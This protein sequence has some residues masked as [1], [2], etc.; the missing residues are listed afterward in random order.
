[1]QDQLRKITAINQG[2]YESMCLSFMNGSKAKLM[3][4]QDIGETSTPIKKLKVLIT[5]RIK[6]SA[7]ESQ[8]KLLTMIFLAR[9][10]KVRFSTVKTSLNNEY[11]VNKDN[12][13]ATLQAALNLLSHYQ[14]NPDKDHSQK[15][16]SSEPLGETS[17]GQTNIKKKSKKQAG[18]SQDTMQ[19]DLT[20][21]ST[22]NWNRSPSPAVLRTL[23]TSQAWSG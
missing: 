6:S 8:D 23:K 5:R 10:C 13:P 7:D 20:Q 22:R 1:M 16:G 2:K 15:K 19:D 21:S 11:L 9:V 12:Y 3:S 18:C 14:D 17:F 4:L